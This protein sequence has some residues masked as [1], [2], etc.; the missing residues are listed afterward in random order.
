[1]TIVYSGEGF[2][3]ADHRDTV[4]TYGKADS[5]KDFINDNLDLSTCQDT[6]ILDKKAAEDF[7]L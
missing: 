4:G 7:T 2:N 5:V 1:M 3:P 6:V